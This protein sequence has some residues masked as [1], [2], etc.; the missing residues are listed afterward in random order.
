MPNQTVDPTDIFVDADGWTPDDDSLTIDAPAGQAAATKGEDLAIPPAR[1]LPADLLPVVAADLTSVNDDSIGDPTK[2]RWVFP[3]E[4]ESIR[5]GVWKRFKTEQLA[6]AGQDDRDGAA[7]S[8]AASTVT[9]APPAPVRF[10]QNEVESSP[11]GVQVRLR[12]DVAGE[13]GSEGKANGRSA[14][15]KRLQEER[16]A[17]E[18]VLHDLPERAEVERLQELSDQNTDRQ[19]AARAEQ[20]RQKQI[21]A[22]AAVSGAATATAEKAL[23][24]AELAE[25]HVTTALDAINPRLSEARQS[26]SIAQRRAVLPRK[27]AYHLAVYNER[28]RIL[29]QINEAVAPL[30]QEFEAA[31]QAAI[32]TAGLFRPFE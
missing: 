27:S 3:D 25:R 23:V 4:G 30:L 14:A 12:W 20:V 17:L 21:I 6:R 16:I 10:F 22:D 7:T 11:G 13:P 2:G 15:D 32:E 29:Q 5:Y 24:K 26:L 19:D 18:T 8:A 31:E 1:A 28:E 9:F